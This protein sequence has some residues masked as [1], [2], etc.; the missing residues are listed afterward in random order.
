[1]TS[2]PMTFF[3]DSASRELA[4]P[5]LQSG[6]ASGLTTN[7]TILKRAGARLSDVP[8][9]YRWA[10]GAGAEEVCFQTW[11]GS[12]D[13]WYSN[14]M[15]LREFAPD[16]VIKVPGTWRGAAV[17]SRLRKQGVTVLLTAGYTHQ[18]IFIASVLGAKYIAPY[19]NRMKLAGRDALAEFGKMTAAIPQDGTD[20]LVL[21][22]SLKSG[23]DVSDL[24]GVGVRAFTAAPE[25]LD[26]LLR[27]DLVD[28][29]VEAFEEDMRGLI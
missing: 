29:A 23:K 20:T 25:V 12:E 28:S 10:L 22:A 7:P 21:A 13:E 6:I 19:F 11:G 24:V 9:I 26:D 17:T 16:A 3:V 2:Y 18:Q 5:W 1:M 27:D 15:R 14:A 8:E 4:E